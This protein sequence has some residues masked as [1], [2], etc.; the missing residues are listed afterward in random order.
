MGRKL[1]RRSF[2]G[3]CG[4]VAAI[5]LARP[6]RAGQPDPSIESA[7][8]WL[9]DSGREPALEHAARALAAGMA[10]EDLLAAI[11]V[12]AARSIRPDVARFNHAALAPAAIA[13]LLPRLDE[14]RR[15]AAIVWCV[16][17]L[18][19]EIDEDRADG[20]W[21]LA[22]LDAPARDASHA[23]A[24]LIGALEDWDQDVA[25]R[26]VA[27]LALAA[28]PAAAFAAARPFGM[29]SQSNIGHQT[30][31]TAAVERFLPR[32]PSALAQDVLRPLV[33][34]FFFGRGGTPNRAA[35]FHVSCAAAERVTTIGAAT[36]RKRADRLRETLR[37]AS[38]LDAPDAV[39]AAL[40]DG[41]AP[42]LIETVILTGA[43][44]SIL[45]RTGL[46]PFHALTSAMAF[47]QLRAAATADGDRIRAALALMQ[48]AAFI[49]FF[50]DGARDPAGR[51][52]VLEDAVKD[53][54]ASRDRA[55][56]ANRL[57][58]VA[59]D[60][61]QFKVSIAALDALESAPPP[62]AAG[63]LVI[64]DQAFPSA[65]A[66]PTATRRRIARAL[67]AAR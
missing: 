42:D 14:G 36:D 22:P 64:A 3:A 53:V 29:R 18:H 56:L 50:R 59:D 43:V 45:T 41:L 66:E 24:E 12:A 65:D 11:L 46:G 17:H 32:L 40:A 31:F 2:L 8:R 23:R 49:T 30:I 44:E 48:C 37:D 19:D 10:H 39:G 62:L 1:S 47:R 20:D 25:E 55:A 27:S 21:E 63:L 54:L 34:S 7:A 4:G 16:D 60:V 33:R 58:D 67:A 61:H 15:R 6:G 51:L 35:P 9:V 26:G 38:S 57:A 5:V 28:G 52:A 13:R